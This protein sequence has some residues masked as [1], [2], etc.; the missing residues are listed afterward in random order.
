MGFQFYVKVLALA[1]NIRL[2]DAG[3]VFKLP[4]IFNDHRGVISHLSHGGDLLVDKYPNTFLVFLDQGI[5]W[6]RAG[7]AS[8]LV[9]GV[10]RILDRLIVYLNNG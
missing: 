8:R 6:S 10:N 2:I 9:Q 7:E 3:R 5:V 4:E 1:F